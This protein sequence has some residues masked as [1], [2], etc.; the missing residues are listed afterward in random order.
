MAFVGPIEKRTIVGFG[1]YYYHCYWFSIYLV[2]GDREGD[3]RAP[4]KYV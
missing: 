4:Y 1:W 2:W 3:Y